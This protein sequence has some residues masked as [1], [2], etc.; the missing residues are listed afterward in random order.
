[1]NLTKA[2]MKK[3]L[4]LIAAGVVL[5]AAVQ[6]LDLLGVFLRVAL[7]LITPFLA[8]SAIA[9]VINVPMRQVEDR[10]FPPLA[11][12]KKAGRLRRAKRPISFVVTLLLLCGLLVVIFFLILPEIGRT[13]QNFV[14]RIPVF[15]Q[16]TQEWGE[17]LMEQYPEVVDVLSRIS[18][19]WEKLSQGFI[20]LAQNSMS[21]VLN[22]T[23]DL[24]SSII[25]GV[26]G[27]VVA[28]VFAAYILLQKERLGRQ[29]RQLL[30]AFLPEHHADRITE[31]GT[32][33]YR[34]FSRFLSGQCLEAVIL[35]C[36][37]FLTMSILRFPYALTISVLITVTA[38]IPIFGAFIGCIVGAFLILTVDPMQAL[39]FV[40]L[41]L[42]LQQVEGN[43]IYPHVVGSSVGLPSIWVLAAVTIGGS[44]MGI[45]GMLIFIPLCSVFYTLLRHSILNRLRARK[46][47]Q[48]K[49]LS[50]K[51]LSDITFVRHG[52]APVVDGP[53]E[54]DGADWDE[55]DEP[56][57]EQQETGEPDEQPDSPE[58][59]AQETEQ[60][61]EQNEAKEPSL[62]QAETE[63]SEEK[64]P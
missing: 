5:N 56:A 12:G 23:L 2:N 55:I 58:P 8:G 17:Q 42:I 54:S 40:V 14:D 13:L 34:T 46:I 33:S 59:P 52:K 30:Y 32:L 19:D 24:A 39:W 53:P 49:I 26:V 9:F 37:F 50:P 31:V 47:P 62:E 22:S 18:I 44:V 21:G 48:E 60:A 63:E 3:L 20:A 10:L 51:K 45:A 38:L 6:H 43:L 41:F 64:K 7:G 35:G 57:V 1:M 28:V 11:A 29:F 16:Q 61:G 27:S 36:M 15:A 4:L 25:G